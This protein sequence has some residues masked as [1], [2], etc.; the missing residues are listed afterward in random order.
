MNLSSSILSVLIES[1][2]LVE[3]SSGKRKKRLT[4]Q[5]GKVNKEGLKMEE[6]DKQ[7]KDLAEARVG[8]G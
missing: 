5:G 3:N 8:K 2:S 4:I 6:K 7:Q 1:S